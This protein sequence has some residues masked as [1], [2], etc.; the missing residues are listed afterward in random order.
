MSNQYR[1]WANTPE[2]ESLAAKAVAFGADEW[3]VS[4]EDTTRAFIAGKEQMQSMLPIFPVLFALTSLD[5]VTAQ[6]QLFFDQLRVAIKED[7]R[8]EILAAVDSI[9][10]QL[11][12]K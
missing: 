10:K 2:L 4:A 11:K 12:H 7:V 3:I 5:L 6:A 1:A 8:V 9:Q